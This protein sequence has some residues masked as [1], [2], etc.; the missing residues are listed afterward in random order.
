MNV[1]GK[2]AGTELHL[3]LFPPVEQEA[4]KDLVSQ[5]NANAE[6]VQQPPAE[7]F[8]FKI[9]FA[10][11]KAY[12]KVR[13][14]VMRS[15]TVAGLEPTLFNNLRHPAVSAGHRDGAQ[16]N[17][18]GSAKQTGVAPH[19]V[20]AGLLPPSRRRSR[21]HPGASAHPQTHLQGVTLRLRVC[22]YFFK[23]ILIFLKVLNVFLCLYVPDRLS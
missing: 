19:L 3:Q 6:Q 10:E 4:N 18:G 21:L 16:E 17:G 11:T 2:Y 15:T 22:V 14:A 20:H 12:A 8:D 9:K 7:L 23:K 1:V 13:Q 5:Q